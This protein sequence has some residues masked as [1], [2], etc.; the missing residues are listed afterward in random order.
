MLNFGSYSSCNTFCAWSFKK[1]IL[2]LYS[3]SW[4]NFIVWLPLLLEISGNVC[5]ANVFY[6][7]CYLISFIERF[8]YIT[9]NS[10]QKLKY[11]KNKK[12]FFEVKWKPIFNFFRRL[13]VVSN[14]LRPEGA[15][16]IGIIIII[17][18]IIIKIIII[19]VY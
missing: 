7:V 10:E 13:S 19:M 8:S 11:L 18:I 9:Q 5:I 2:K 17:I 14:C 12:E 6:W 3:I 1:T 15:T 4:L 16:L